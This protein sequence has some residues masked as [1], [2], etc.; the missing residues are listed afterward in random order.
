MSCRYMRDVHSHTH[1]HTR[2]H[3]HVY[4]ISCTHTHI[5]YYDVILWTADKISTPPLH[6]HTHNDN[7]IIQLRSR[8]QAGTGTPTPHGDYL[9]AGDGNQYARIYYSGSPS[10]VSL[11]QVFVAMVSP[12]RSHVWVCSAG[13]LCMIYY[14]VITILQYRY[15]VFLLVVATVV[16]YVD[17]H[18]L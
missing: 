18:A 12:S 3:V 14:T 4:I 16:G 17:L 11:P 9:F 6:T 7:F 2:M 5:N 13:I 15:Y 8:R 10:P 1:T